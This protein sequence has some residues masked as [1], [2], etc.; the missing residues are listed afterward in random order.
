[1]EYDDAGGIEFVEMHRFCHGP[2]GLVHIRAGQ[3]QERSL[4]R[5]ISLNRNTLKPP[6]PGRQVVAAR[7]RLNGHEPD[8]MAVARVLGAGI[9]EADEKQH[10][11]NG[12]KTALPQCA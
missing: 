12:R 8:I 6:P 1:M 5:D 3:Q 9:A 7:D 2:T 11:F 10:G 4:V